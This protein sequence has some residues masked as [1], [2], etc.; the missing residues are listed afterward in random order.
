MTITITTI[1]LYRKIKNNIF[2]TS[3]YFM[4][5]KFFQLLG[6]SIRAEMLAVNAI[7]LDY[8]MP[9]IKYAT[10]WSL[11]LIIFSFYVI[12]AACHLI[13]FFGQNKAHIVFS[14]MLLLLTMCFIGI[15]VLN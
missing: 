6:N 15:V 1:D 12:A 8:G 9:V 4:G 2:D 14:F 11:P 3:F 10:T 7:L 5:G 13:G